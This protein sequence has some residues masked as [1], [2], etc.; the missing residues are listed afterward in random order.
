MSSADVRSHDG[1]RNGE[2]GLHH[3]SR[4]R[5][6]SRVAEL[7][8]QPKQLLVERDAVAPITET[9]EPVVELAPVITT[10]TYRIDRMRDMGRL[11][12]AVRVEVRDVLSQ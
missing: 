10:E 5:G 2:P 9:L 7:G 1:H 8:Y 11:R 12:A 4:Q 6:C 3:F